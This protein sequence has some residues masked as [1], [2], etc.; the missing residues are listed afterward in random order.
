[1]R[2]VNMKASEDCCECLRRLAYQAAGQ[3]TNDE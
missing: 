2:G 3:A 1:M